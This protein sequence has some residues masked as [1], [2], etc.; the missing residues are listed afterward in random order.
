[1]R[2]LC[3]DMPGTFNHTLTVG[4]ISDMDSHSVFQDAI[5]NC[6]RCK[7]PLGSA[8]YLKTVKRMLGKEDPMMKYCNACK[9]QIA[10]EKLF[11]NKR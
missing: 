7:K 9:Q 11:G 1:M 10:V 3:T 5:V 2:V 8:T 6:A 4:R